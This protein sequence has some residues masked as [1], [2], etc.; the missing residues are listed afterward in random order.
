MDG[1]TLMYGDGLSPPKSPGE[2]IENIVRAYMRDFPYSRHA[3]ENAVPL[4]G[5]LPAGLAAPSTPT[6]TTGRPTTATG[7]TTAAPVTTTPTTTTTIA[8][9][10]APKDR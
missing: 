8:A 2:L 3:L 10:L 4:G 9:C 5:A 7:T 1:T 6:G